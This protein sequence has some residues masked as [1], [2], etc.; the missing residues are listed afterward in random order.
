LKFDKYDWPY[1]HDDY[2]AYKKAHKCK[3]EKYM[4]CVNA[5]G[6]YVGSYLQSYTYNAGT[7]VSQPV[8]WYQTTTTTQTITNATCQQVYGQ[9]VYGQGYGGTY[10]VGSNIVMSIPETEEQRLEREQ[11]H[12]DW[13]AKEDARNKRAREALV[14]ILTDEQRKQFETDKHFDLQV[15][16]RLYRISPGTRVQR[17]DPQTKETLS[18]FCIH[19]DLSHGLPG[20]D[21]ALAQTLLLQADETSFLKIANETKVTLDATCTPDEARHAAIGGILDALNQVGVAA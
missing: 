1:E 15:N 11:K 10:T 18:Y 2:M 3:K 6:N 7:S 16:D 19:P 12:R 17:L 21:V 5:I 13:Q 9:Q 4:P 8:V 20:A 14:T